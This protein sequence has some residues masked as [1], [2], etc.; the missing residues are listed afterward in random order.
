VNYNA[1]D[2]LFGCVEMVLASSKVKQVIVV[3]N[4]S[5]DDSFKRV[6][7]LAGDQRLQLIE[8]QK[9]LGFS[10]ANN[11]AME[12]LR[13]E[14]RYILFLNPDCEMSEGVAGRLLDFMENN[15]DVGMST[16]L[17]ANPDGSE[18]RGCRRH[19]PDL[20][21]TLAA[22]FPWSKTACRHDFNLSETPLPSAPVEVEAI[23]GS[24]MFV[25]RTVIEAIG[26]FDEGY[27]LHCEDLD[28]CK[29]I[30]L[31]GWKMV[32]GVDAN[33]SR[34]LLDV[35]QTI[36]RLIRDGARDFS[37]GQ[38]VIRGTYPRRV[39]LCH[40]KTGKATSPAHGAGASLIEI[41]TENHDTRHNRR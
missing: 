4:A 1:G 30:G 19:I 39:P 41:P 7:R 28:L 8:N 14:S 26:G 34:P 12:K 29:R 33:V 9:N 21:N 36:T 11:M 16:C 40:T 35:K 25:R 5:R 32:S 27:F 10:R 37:A 18:Q 13:P 24:F 31:A 2:L 6:R 22:L 15:E 23:S 17:V 3:D 20:G 38:A